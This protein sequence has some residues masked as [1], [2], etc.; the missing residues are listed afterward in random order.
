MARQGD[1]N[2]GVQLQYPWNLAV[3]LLDSPYLAI[4]ITVIR[5]S[6]CTTGDDGNPL[7]A[8]PLLRK[9]PQGIT[10]EHR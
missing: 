5:A 1:E 7:G 10:F 3:K 6:S 8:S 9:P 4:E 2:V